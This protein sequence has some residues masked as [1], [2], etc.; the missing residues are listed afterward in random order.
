MDNQKV[1]THK[2]YTNMQVDFMKQI[3]DTIASDTKKFQGMTL[4]KTLTDLNNI[5]DSGRACS[6]D[7]PEENNERSESEE[8][9]QSNS[10]TE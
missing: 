7:I 9:S 2:I 1:M 6:I 10:E 4:I 5:L 3:L 8:D